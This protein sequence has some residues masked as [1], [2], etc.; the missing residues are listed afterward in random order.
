MCTSQAATSIDWRRAQVTATA[1][2]LGAGARKFLFLT[3]DA[4]VPSFRYRLDPPIAALRSLGHTCD[5]LQL[6][7]GRYYRRLYALRDR[8]READAVIVAKAKLT[9]PE[10]AMLRRW[11]TKLAF[12]FDDAIYVRRPRAPGL[13]PGDSRW[14]RA[15]FAAT[16]AAMDL[17]MAGNETLAAA[18]VPHS[19]RVEVVPT[20]VDFQRYRTATFDV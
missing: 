2:R 13:H 7:S 18:A 15:K 14:R 5:V 20:P 11:C 10:P 12:D 19:A 4:A 8:L 6:P 1:A 9:P 17:V 16:C 3:Y